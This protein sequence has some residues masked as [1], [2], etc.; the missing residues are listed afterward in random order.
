MG[1]FAFSILWAVMLSSAP[2]LDHFPATAY[3]GVSSSAKE[4]HLGVGDGGASVTISDDEEAK[5]IKYGLVG[6]V[7]G[8]ALGG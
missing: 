2:G 6:A 5:W 3:S 7:M 1:E 4:S 8:L